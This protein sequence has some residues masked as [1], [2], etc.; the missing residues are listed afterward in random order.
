MNL[1]TGTCSKCRGLVLLGETNGTKVAVDLTPVDAQEAVRAV[2][3]GR[4]VYRLR[5]GASGPQS[6]TVHRGTLP[7]DGTPILA[8]HPCGSTAGY[9]AVRTPEVTSDPKEAPA[10]PRTPS[11]APVTDSPAPGARTAVR[12]R[13]EHLPACGLCG[14]R[15]TPEVPYVAAQLGATY[16]WAEHSEACPP[17]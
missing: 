1:R 3:G 5:I 6:L 17:A 16:V 7:Q 2:L 4:Q 13:T 10:A 14:V 8:D 12:P 15:L 9:K 11:P